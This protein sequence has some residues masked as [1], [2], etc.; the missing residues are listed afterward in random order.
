[1]DHGVK[2]EHNIITPNAVPKNPEPQ[3]VVHVKPSTQHSPVEEFSNVGSSLGIERFGFTACGLKSWALG[4]GKVF[5][6]GSGFRVYGLWL[7]GSKR[8]NPKTLKNP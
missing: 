7:R 6:V 4:S 2:P 8:L 3:T 5:F 1:M